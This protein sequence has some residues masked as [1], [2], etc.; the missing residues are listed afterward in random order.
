M[1]QDDMM[2]FDALGCTVA[3]EHGI[4]A[5]LPASGGSSGSIGERRC[6]GPRLSV[7]AAP[8]RQ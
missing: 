5:L 3:E 6:Y 1:L 2:A 8:T 4:T 7:G